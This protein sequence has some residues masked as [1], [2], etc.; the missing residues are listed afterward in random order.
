MGER[1][2]VAGLMYRAHTK[3]MTGERCELLPPVAMRVRY[4]SLS[5]T[6]ANMTN[7]ESNEN[8]SKIQRDRENYWMVWV[9]KVM[10][11]FV[12]SEIISGLFAMFPL[13]LQN[14]SSHCSKVFNKRN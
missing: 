14:M 2:K 7:I 13:D 12:K 3:Q 1:G 4:W 8:E 10:I 6:L 11:R 5:S 9:C